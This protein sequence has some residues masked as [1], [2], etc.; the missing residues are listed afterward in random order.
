L[1][2]Q[3][4]NA[5]VRSSI[6]QLPLFSLV[7]SGDYRA[8]MREILTAIPLSEAQKIKA[9]VASI[10]FGTPFPRDIRNMVTIKLIRQF[11]QQHMEYAQK[12][13]DD[14]EFKSGYLS[15]MAKQAI[16]DLREPQTWNAI[17]QEV[18]TNFRRVLARPLER[19]GVPQ[20]TREQQEAVNEEL[21]G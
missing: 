13:L 1:I 4:A 3:G 12:L 8:T 14:V 2:E 18:V 19:V 6:S 9:A 17:R 21:Y 20:L 15:S 10:K 11:T 5:N 16:A 7:S